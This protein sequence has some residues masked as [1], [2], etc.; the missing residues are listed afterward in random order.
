[1]SHSTKQFFYGALYFVLAVLIVIL[2]LPRRDVAKVL[3]PAPEGIRGLEMR[4]AVTIMTA[5]DGS[6]ALLARVKNPNTAHA[7]TSFPY[8]FRIVGD[9]VPLAETPRRAGFVYPG[10][11]MV[12]L[13]HVSSAEF[14][15]GARAELAIGTPIWEPAGF[16]VR[17]AV[18]VPRAGLGSDELGAF[19]RGEAQN[20]SAVSASTVRIIAIAS[21]EN[22]FPLFAAQTLL[23]NL[24]G[25]ASRA[26]FIRFPRDQALASR[27]VAGSF[28]L[29]WDA[30]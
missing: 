3:V 23:E 20:A 26:F 9:A 5:A 19:V 21:D 29:A 30:K 28:E 13:E 16:L 22:E 18:T 24:A 7:A 11:T 12:L 4:G 14:S 15:E 10:E 2:V 25:G 6:V 8:S 1:M 17:P 27:A